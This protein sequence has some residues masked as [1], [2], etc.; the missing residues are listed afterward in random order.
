MI[1]MGLPF[2]PIVS[3][4][5]KRHNRDAFVCGKPAMDK[6]LQTRS[7]QDVKR[8]M[9][10]VFVLEG[11]HDTDIAGFYTL[12][13][14]SIDAGDLTEGAAKGLPK[15]RP[16][17]CTLLGQF[18][19]HEKWQGQGVANWL[20]GYVLKDVLA[21]SKRISSFALVLD[22]IDDDARSYWLH[23]G[24]IPFPETPNRLFLPMKIIRQLLE[25]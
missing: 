20:L 4:L 12:S 9:T 25:E 15:E 16:I 18:G 24:F 5:K 6:Y 7:S 21:A 14:L 13:S 8:D 10:V 1:N 2:D 11:E 17:G 19:V 3:P 22:A 23:C